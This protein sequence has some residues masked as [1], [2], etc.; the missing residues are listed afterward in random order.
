LP[1]VGADNEPFGENPRSTTASGSGA[2]L[3]ML[4]PIATS[5]APEHPQPHQPR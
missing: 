3:L 1:I 4:S 2:T 5:L